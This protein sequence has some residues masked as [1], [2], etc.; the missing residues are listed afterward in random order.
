VLCGGVPLTAE[1]ARR[2][3]CDA[4]IIRLITGQPHSQ[5]PPGQ[6]PPSQPPP[7][8]AG[9][10]GAPGKDADAALDATAQLTALLA[11][12]IARLPRPLGAPSA[13]LDIGRKS[14]SWTPRQRDALYAQYGGR[15]CRP[16]CTR[17]ID[18]IHHI[19][20]WLY[21]GKTQIVN[22]APVCLYDHW[23][24]H[25]GGWRVTRQPEG[26]LT[27]IPPPP[28][29]RPGT[30]YRRGKPLAEDGPHSHAA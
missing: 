15:C 13:A 10:P 19:I 29:W 6:P 20:H 26:T 1:A 27:F 9:P 18:V 17:P 3:S 8:R 7:G 24:V 28:G 21:G 4:E 30:I 16:G 5:P 12:A 2:L 11:D 14:Q 22:G 25:E 23:L